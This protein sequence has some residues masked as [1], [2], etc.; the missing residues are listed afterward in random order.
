MICEIMLLDSFSSSSVT[1]TLSQTL[2]LSCTTPRNSRSSFLRI[3]RNWLSARLP[4]NS[5]VLIFLMNLQYGP[6]GEN[7]KEEL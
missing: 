5:N 3:G 4:R 1:L 6:Y 2:D 7:A